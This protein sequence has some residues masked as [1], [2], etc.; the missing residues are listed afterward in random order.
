MKWFYDL[1]TKNKLF[2]AFGVMVALLA[3][4]V[5]TA[6]SA[7]TALKDSQKNMAADYE[8]SVG[9][10]EIRANQTEIR[11]KMLAMLLVKDRTE[12]ENRH[13]DI[14]KRSERILDLV[15][16]L[17]GLLKDDPDLYP[18]F[19]EFESVREQYA[20]VREK[21]EIPLIFE[22]KSAEV[23][24][25][26]FGVQYQRS[27]QMKTI[28]DGL[29]SDVQKRAENDIRFSGKRVDQSLTL[30][31]A[32]SGIALVCGVFL[33]LF[34]NRIIAVP[35][36]EVAV[37]AER[38]ASGD[39][40]A[41]AQFAERGDEVGIL[42]Q[43]F[44]K[45]TG[46]LT[47]IANVAEKISSGDLTVTVEPH[48]GK[49]IL[50]KTLSTMT[51]NLRD[52]TKEIQS[53]VN[54]LASSAAEILA[55]T[56]EVASGAA[57]TASAVNETTTTVEEVK[58]TS[59]VSSQKA[60]YVSETA[61]KAVKVSHS[62][63]KSVQETIDKMNRIQDQMTAVAESIIR[64]SEQS[65]A[66]GEIIATV[67]DLAEQSNLLAVNASIEAA[68][69]GEQ[70][71]GF[72]VVAQ[73]VKSLAEQSKHATAQVRVIL[74]DIQKA[75]SAAVLATEQGS[76][77]VEAGVSQSGQ[78]GEAIRVLAESISEAAQ[79]ATQIAASSQQQLIGMEQ[80]ITAMDN[81]KQASEQN[82]TGTRQTE[83]A[84]QNLHE[85]GQKLKGLVEQYKV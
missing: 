68:K 77:S 83:T 73:E 28:S 47:G 51:A 74:G 53:S 1:S 8:V 12:Q 79:A 42:M 60:R 64:L 5:F 58:Q 13:E 9:L 38:I 69:A 65:Q 25:I 66:I 33:T 26:A 80:I 46:Y 82:V 36:G 52:M 55:S 17:N 24:K 3:A 61:Q 30:F 10:T 50:G 57:E 45:M 22:G 2:T 40:T 7:L 6:F 34:L 18:K 44:S 63:G 23:S 67:N 4:V 59:Q 56:T 19:R 70:G 78:A 32:L 27:E 39:L 71:R 62:G 37:V 35:L 11:E 75:T 16:R 15:Q 72:A 81:I 31:F 29:I 84:A 54:V 49:D 85:L 48:S 20:E 43:T 14:K 21:Q 76:K 41:S